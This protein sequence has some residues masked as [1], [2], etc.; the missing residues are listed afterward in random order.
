[1]PMAVVSL[2]FLVLVGAGIQ[3]VSG[4]LYRDQEP[5]FELHEKIVYTALFGLLWLAVIAEF[6]VVFRS[7]HPGESLWKN[8]RAEF[9]ACLIPPLRMALSSRAMDRR[10]WV[11]TLGWQTINRDLRAKLERFFSIPMIVVALM[12]LP[13]LAVEHFWSEK[14]HPHE[15]LWLVVAI[16]GS[17]AVIW[18][19]FA[20]EFIVM[21]SVADNKFRY[22]KQHWLDLAIILLPLISFLRALRVIRLTR[23]GRL[24]SVGR[25]SRLYRLRGL[26][27]RAFRALLLLDVIARVIGRSPQK[28]LNKLLTIL[29]EKE[30]EV[31]DLRREI[32]RL[33]MLIAQQATQAAPPSARESTPPATENI[34]QHTGESIG[35]IE[36]A[37]TA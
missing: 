9:L 11:P 15:H 33:E 3:R 14:I 30:A 5:H 23:L 2:L 4:P 32:A 17:T 20:T 28:Q 25:V 37:R 36:S 19:A 26:A 27:I 31:A 6:V 1:M 35:P 29:A 21:Y 18:I 8:Y 34:A 12:I 10:V 16:D 7:R 24:T 22:C 13:I